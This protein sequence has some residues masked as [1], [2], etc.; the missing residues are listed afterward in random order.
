M[1]KCKSLGCFKFK[2]N[3]L[4]DDSNNNI[5]IYWKIKCKLG[6]KRF[7]DIIIENKHIY[8]FEISEHVDNVIIAAIKKA[9]KKRKPKKKKKSKKG[10]KKKKKWN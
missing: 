5:Y 1:V 9:T 8:K 4:Y 2:Y 3:G 7:M 10:K 6:C